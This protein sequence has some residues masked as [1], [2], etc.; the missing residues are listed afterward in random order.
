MIVPHAFGLLNRYKDLC[1]LIEYKLRCFELVAL[2][3]WNHSGI[4][5]YMSL[6]KDLCKYAVTTS[7]RRKSNPSKTAKQIRHLNVVA[8]IIGGYVFS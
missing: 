4:F 6:S 1:R 5:I 2:G 3:I 8:S 7:M